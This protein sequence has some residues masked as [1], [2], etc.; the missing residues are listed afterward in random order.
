MYK[1]TTNDEEGQVPEITGC[2]QRSSGNPRRVQGRL[3]ALQGSPDP[4][5]SANSGQASCGK[6]EV[7]DG[8]LAI[9]LEQYQAR[10]VQW[11]PGE[12]VTDAQRGTS[13]ITT[14]P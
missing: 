1:I 2:T 14:V 4:G 12:P 5:P 8:N 7:F 10:L 13:S 6:I 9:P 3:S 11:K